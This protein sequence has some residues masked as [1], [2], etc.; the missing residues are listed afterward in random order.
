MSAADIQM[1]IRRIIQRTSKGH[2][3]DNP[4]D[5]HIGPS[6]DYPTDVRSLAGCFHLFVIFVILHFIA[7]LVV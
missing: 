2:N 6:L 7:Q 5:I 1:N 3:Q 4:A